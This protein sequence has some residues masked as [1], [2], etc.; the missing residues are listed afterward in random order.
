[1]A[2]DIADLVRCL[3]RHAEAVCRR[4]LSNGHREGQY[5]H[6]GNLQNEP[7]RSLFVRL[8]GP[9]AGKWADSATGDHGDLLDIIRATCRLDNFHEVAEEAQS[10]LNMPT[11][12]APDRQETRQAQS[13]A[14]N[15]R[16]ACCL[17]DAGKPISGTVAG[18]YLRN[19][20]IT[21]LRNCGALRFH[22][23]CFHRANDRSQ[24]IKLPAIIAAVTDLPGNVTGVHRTWLARDG[25]DKASVETPRR[26]LGHLSGNAVRFGLVNEI[27]CIG[28]GI[29]TVLSLKMALPTMPMAAAL[30]AGNLSRILF[31]PTLHRLYIAVDNDP[32]GE[33]AAE[34]LATRATVEGIEAVPLRPRLGDFN[35][36]LQHYGLDAVRQHVQAQLRECDA[37]RF[38]DVDACAETGA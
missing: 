18:A 31:P 10:F 25:S 24:T 5:W 15:Q 4:Y 17:L 30:S 33:Q 34:T 27:W 26:A 29:E 9:S 35:D 28:E 38:V 20:G 6:V 13:P 19:R 21:D 12:D 14:R 7:G 16:A 2:T 32:A 22:P 3:A 8:S 37:E 11:P 23:E 36:D 1:M